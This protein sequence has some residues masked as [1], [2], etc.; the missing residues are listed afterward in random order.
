MAPASVHKEKPTTMTKTTHTREHARMAR[1]RNMLLRSACLLQHIQ[2]IRALSVRMAADEAAQT[3]PNQK[4]LAGLAHIEESL[5]KA[6][7]AVN[8]HVLQVVFHGMKA[9]Q[10]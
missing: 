10:I 4:H 9:T 6:Q 7:T 5:R 3:R 8:A 1:R 2:A